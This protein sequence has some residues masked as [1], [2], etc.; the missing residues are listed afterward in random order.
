MRNAPEDRADSIRAAQVEAHGA[1]PIFDGA[2]ATAASQNQAATNGT[3][4]LAQHVHAAG[5]NTGTC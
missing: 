1:A 2:M 3:F 5:R 4:V